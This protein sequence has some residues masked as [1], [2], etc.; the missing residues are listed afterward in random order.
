MERKLAF[1]GYSIVKKA[2][3]VGFHM[4]VNAKTSHISKESHSERL[5]HLK[6]KPM[7]LVVHL[8]TNHS[9]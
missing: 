9:L 4:Y 2:F 6:E 8:T 3:V 5:M 1:F 7:V